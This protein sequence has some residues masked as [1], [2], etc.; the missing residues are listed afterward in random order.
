MSECQAKSKD[1]NSR[2]KKLNFKNLK[3]RVWSWLRLNAGGNETDQQ[4]DGADDEQE[5]DGE[6]ALFIQRDIAVVPERVDHINN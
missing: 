3:W 1:S 5:Q 2:A 6:T 4:V